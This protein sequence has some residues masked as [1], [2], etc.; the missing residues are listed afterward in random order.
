MNPDIVLLF[1]K[2]FHVR[3][4]ST[5]RPNMPVIAGRTRKRRRKRHGSFRIVYR[6]K[7]TKR[8]RTD[9]AISPIVKIHNNASC[10]NNPVRILERK[11]SLTKTGYKFLNVCVTLERSSRVNIILGDSHG[12]EVSM[13]PDTWRQLVEQRHVLSKY[14]Q[15]TNGESS[16]PA[17]SH[18]GNMTVHFGKINNMTIL[19]LETSATRLAMSKKTVNNMFELEHCVIQ[20]VISLTKILEKINAKLARFKDIA[21][22]AKDTENISRVIRDSDAFDR[23]DIIDCELVALYF[24]I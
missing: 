24:G 23:N 20:L 1:R 7:D 2:G 9:R 22:T 14:L 11:Y 19:R 21:F 15:S 4:S 13:S 16:F 17:S 5:S 8:L 3:R 18:I 6:A 10:T 12:K